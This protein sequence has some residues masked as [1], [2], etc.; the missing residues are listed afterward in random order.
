MQYLPIAGKDQFIPG[1]TDANIALIGR[2]RGYYPWGKNR[3]FK[4]GLFQVKQIAIIK[5]FGSATQQEYQDKQINYFH[6]L[7]SG[8]INSII[9][10][11][12]FKHRS[13]KTA[14]SVS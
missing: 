14:D 13:E 7:V 4:L 5:L 3:W 8:G 1:F 2:G 6:E 10:L 11:S 9:I 12:E